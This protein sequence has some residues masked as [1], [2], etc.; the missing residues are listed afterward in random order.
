MGAFDKGG[1][2]DKDER[3]PSGAKDRNYFDEAG[4]A[5]LMECESLSE[6]VS[7]KDGS[8][9][10]IYEGTVIETTDERRKPGDRIGLVIFL[11]GNPRAIKTK[12][13]IVRKLVAAHL[14]KR[15]EDTTQA[16]VAAALKPANPCL[17]KRA[18]CKTIAS[19]QYVNQEWSPAP[20]APAKGA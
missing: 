6:K 4:H 17:G 9:L 7:E 19:G 14:G 8:D 13:G 11:S 1:D 16:E 3:P 2:F 18:Y 5:Y 15:W 12:K 10:V 20:A